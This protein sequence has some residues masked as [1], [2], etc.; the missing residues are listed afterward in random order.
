MTRDSRSNQIDVGYCAWPRAGSP[1]EARS[2]EPIGI[3]VVV[4]IFSWLASPEAKVKDHYDDNDDEND[5]C[6][7]A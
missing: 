7:D 4:G 3:K 6:D 2:V 1:T 5:T